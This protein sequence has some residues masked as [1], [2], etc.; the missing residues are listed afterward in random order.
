MVLR[1][2]EKQHAMIQSLLREGD[3]KTRA[4]LRRRGEIEKILTHLRQGELARTRTIL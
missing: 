1:H 3:E 2:L 4:Q